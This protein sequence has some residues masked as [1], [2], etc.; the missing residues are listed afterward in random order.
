MTSSILALILFLVSAVHGAKDCS[1]K[2]AVTGC[3]GLCEYKIADPSVPVHVS[4]VCIHEMPY[5]F[6][7]FYALTKCCKPVGLYC[8]SSAWSLGVAHQ[9]NDVSSMILMR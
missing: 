7:L 2:P 1:A 9:G 8:R 3:I 6:F 4:V 5:W